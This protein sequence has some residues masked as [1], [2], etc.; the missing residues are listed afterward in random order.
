M[1][2]QQIKAYIAIRNTVQLTR[3]DSVSNEQIV[4]AYQCTETL[5]KVASGLLNKAYNRHS[6]VITGARGIGKSHL[7]AL[8]RA[9]IEQPT[10]TR[11]IENPIARRQI[12][13]ALNQFTKQYT[14]ITL[15]FEK[16]KENFAQFHERCQQEIKETLNRSLAT[17]IY[18]D[19]LTPLLN[20][21]KKTET[22]HW[23][24]E[25]CR[26]TTK[27]YLLFTAIDQEAINESH[28]A[29]SY[30]SQN[31]LLE[32]IP[33]D[34]LSSVF[35]QFICV[36]KPE[37]RRSLTTVFQQLQKVM[38]HFKWSER[39][40]IECFPLHPMI[41]QIAPVLR[42]NGRAFSLF[43]FFYSVASRGIMRRGYNIT[44]LADLFES[45]EF[46][47]RRTAKLKELFETFDDLSENFV[48]G[49]PD[50]QRMYGK[51]LIQG[52][53]LL[54]ITEKGYT[55]E[56]MADSVMIFDDAHPTLLRQSLKSIIDLLVIAAGE[57]LI[58]SNDANPR[59]QFVITSQ[60][61]VDPIAEA[62][63]EIDDTDH[64]L[65]EL[66][67]DSA[68]LLLKDWPLVFDSNTG[69]FRRRVEMELFWHGTGRRGVVKLGGQSELEGSR[70]EWQLTIVSPFSVQKVRD[71]VKRNQPLCYWYPAG[72]SEDEKQSLKRLLI[73]RDRGEELLGKDKMREEMNHL[74]IQVAQ[75]LTRCYLDFGRIGG[76]DAETTS[77]FPSKERR[78]PF[79]FGALFDQH[80]KSRYPQHPAFGD[81]L[82]EKALRLLA[83]GFFYQSEWTRPELKKMLGQFALPLHIVIL[84]GERFEYALRGDIPEESPLGK[85]LQLLEQDEAHTISRSKM[86][87]ILRSAPYGLQMPV[88]LLLVLGA[89][90]AGHIILTDSNGELILTSAG[91]RS[92]FDVA[93]FNN[94]SLP[95][96]LYKNEAELLTEH[97]EERLER[98]FDQPL[99]KMFQDVV[100]EA[101]NA[102]P[103]PTQPLPD[104]EEEDEILEFYQSGIFSRSQLLNPSDVPVQPPS[105]EKAPQITGPLKLPPSVAAIETAEL[106][107]NIAPGVTASILQ[108]VV[109]EEIPFSLELPPPDSL[110][111]SPINEMTS[112][113]IFGIEASPGTVET[114]EPV[115]STTSTQT[116]P[117]TQVEAPVEVQ[118]DLNAWADLAMA[119]VTETEALTTEPPALVKTADPVSRPVLATAEISSTIAEPVNSVEASADILEIP[120]S[121]V[122]P[123]VNLDLA[124]AS[125]DLIMVEDI[126]D[127]PDDLFAVQ[128]PIIATQQPTIKA[129]T[130]VKVTD[131]EPV[132][133]EADTAL[134]DL[135][136]SIASTGSGKLTPAFAFSQDLNSN[137]V[138]E[139]VSKSEVS[140][141]APPAMTTSAPVANL[142]VK[143]SP[144]TDLSVEDINLLNPN[145][146]LSLDNSLTSTPYLPTNYLEN[147]QSS[148]SSIGSDALA[149][150]IS[151]S[152]TIPRPNI[153]ML[154][155][156]TVKTVIPEEITPPATTINSTPPVT[157]VT[158]PGKAVAQGPLEAALNEEV[159]EKESVTIPTP[160]KKPAFINTDTFKPN[161]HKFTRPFNPADVPTLLDQP[162][163]S[164]EEIQQEREAFLAEQAL[165]EKD[166]NSQLSL[167]EQ[168]A[169]QQ[170]LAKQRAVTQAVDVVDPE[171]IKEQEALKEKE[172]SA[173]Q[174][175][176][177]DQQAVIEQPEAIEAEVVLD[178]QAITEQEVIQEDLIQ[179]EIVEEQI[180]EEQIVVEE[181]IVAEQILAEQ[182][183]TIAEPVATESAIVEE[184][185]INE[186]VPVEQSM[187]FDLQIDQQIIAEHEAMTEESAI[188]SQPSIPQ[189]FSDEL[190]QALNEEQAIEEQQVIQQQTI[191]EQVIQE[192]Q[193]IEEQQAIEEEQVVNTQPEA[194][195]TS[196]G[197][198]G[199]IVLENFD[200]IDIAPLTGSLRAINLQSDGHKVRREAIP[201]AKRSIKEQFNRSMGMGIPTAPQNEANI[202]TANLP[203]LPPEI[204]EALAAVDNEIYFSNAHISESVRITVKIPSPF[205]NIISS[206]TG[207]NPS[208]NL[209]PTS[210]PVNP[211]LASE[212]ST[213]PVVPS[214]PPSE[215]ALPPGIL[216]P[217]AA[218]VP[219]AAPIPVTPPAAIATPA[220]TP[221]WFAP[222]LAVQQNDQNQQQNVNTDKKAPLSPAELWQK[223]NTT[224]STPVPEPEH[225]REAA[226]PTEF[227]FE[228][229]FLRER[230]ERAQAET[231][232]LLPVQLPPEAVE[233][234]TT[235]NEIAP[236]PT[237]A[238]AAVVNTPLINLD[239]V[240]KPV[241]EPAP[242]PFNS[243]I[244]PTGVLPANPDLHSLILAKKLNSD[245]IVNKELP[246]IY[247][248]FLALCQQYPTATPMPPTF[249]H[250]RSQIEQCIKHLV[251]Q[252]RNREVW[253]QLE[254][255]KGYIRVYCYSGRTSLF[256]KRAPK[257]RIF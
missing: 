120:I 6:V 78:L 60:P 97:R 215:P 68:K 175:T 191:E 164:P 8:T 55:I 185:I 248:K 67:F 250:F 237:R 189:Y 233:E 194:A 62:M 58:V 188:A 74:T 210:E 41:F 64:R 25:L 257:I 90:A 159:S 235:V 3:F 28:P 229:T 94:I 193:V 208:A 254:I 174:P 170:K 49:L 218:N 226:L 179:E 231:K 140:A 255:V 69:N 71:K 47:L 77:T 206:Q 53:L 187:A 98:T 220:P 190:V 73:L 147:N 158:I 19:G 44:N 30:F 152:A 1:S 195:G 118:V 31:Q 103:A 213:A 79:L 23:L 111:T 124:V 83:R 59:Y 176:V 199:Q 39:E 93:Q 132:T 51:L 256:Q 212:N 139:A 29:I 91:I 246:N 26:D 87:S 81:L 129:T 89:A 84:I 245:I 223:I 137:N 202:P 198:S 48:R 138:A 106:Y 115:A 80:L 109:E 95:A 13:Q 52:L 96:I 165:L 146:V 99:E 40:F 216:P 61:K 32:S 65:V 143:E 228:S 76:A 20:G 142:E 82:S 56:E 134:S 33:K 9:L 178:Q 18:I 168:Y 105:T 204:E 130:S 224:P 151:S 133:N 21:D 240:P 156:D 249:S 222:P 184:V 113:V 243:N 34:C 154:V 2:L 239:P 244:L 203:P 234:I 252:T 150:L 241:M 242:Q 236:L 70:M 247:E 183:V 157:P 251:S 38:P 104:P 42:A 22:L 110:T 172:L 160:T 238:P 66:L 36:K 197:E 86:E 211:T 45:F 209:N 181:P 141:L 7:L 192:E 219:P 221:L 63:V 75:I 128:K 144:I 88:L 167:A 230:K 12:E 14:A 225:M 11:L 101:L 119:G 116:Q 205:E 123:A 214:A 253:C 112:A 114:V 5:A 108:P 166:P 15:Y 162:I 227:T 163:L 153:K 200:D 100:S 131:K 72:L 85:L 201:P 217:P 127:I 43:G 173:E 107:E 16:E 182:P 207:S 180:V 50:T 135:V 37:Q 24:M 4:T 92:G 17:A 102:T 145:E 161:I 125:S 171:V 196:G 54:S 27:G 155:P 57:R 169:L 136:N 177:V 46:D 149:S 121:V 148:D 126:I 35:D 186:P 122:Q 232:P 117:D 10:L